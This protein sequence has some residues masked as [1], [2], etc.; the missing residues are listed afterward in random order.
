[1]PTAAAIGGGAAL[2]AGAN[3]FGANKAASAQTNAAN[4]AIQAQENMFGQAQNALNPFINA[5]SSVLPTIQQLLTPG[6]NMSAVLSQIPGFQFAQ[7][8]GQKAITNQATSRGLSGNALTA[9]ADYATGSANSAYGGILQALLGLSGQGAQA[10]GALAGN[11]I[12]TGANI[13]GALTNRGQAQAGGATG[14]TN[15]IAGAGGTIGNLATLNALTGGNLLNS[16]NMYGVT[17]YGDPETAQAAQAGVAS[18]L[19]YNPLTGTV[20]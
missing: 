8:Y 15:A 19:T 5:G 9:G 1:M 18:G 2:T 13:G 6:A 3:I 16:A 11:A 12:Q 17:N 7:Q 4:A 10:G 14:T 20:S